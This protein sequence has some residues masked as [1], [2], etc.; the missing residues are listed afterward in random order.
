ML[1][2]PV[3]HVERFKGRRGRKLGTNVRK[4]YIFSIMAPIKTYNYQIWRSSDSNLKIVKNYN[5]INI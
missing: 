2:E 1:H 5:E 3:P 4:L